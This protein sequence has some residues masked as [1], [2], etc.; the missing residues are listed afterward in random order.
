MHSWTGILIKLN[1]ISIDVTLFHIETNINMFFFVGY[2]KTYDL[3]VHFL[4]FRSLKFPVFKRV[5]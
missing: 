3:L 1:I 4:N 2:K 5:R